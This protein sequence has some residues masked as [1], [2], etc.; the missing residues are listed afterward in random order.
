M[1][2]NNFQ[3][4]KKIKIGYILSYNDPKYIRTIT[5]LQALAKS[6]KNKIYT[7]INSNRSVLRYIETLFRLVE[8]RLKYNP[9]M[10]ILGFRGYEIYWPV[11]LLTLGKPL[12]FDD[13]V[14]PYH[15]IVFEHKIFSQKSIFAKM[16]YYSEKFILASS[17]HIIT[18]TNLLKDFLCNTFQIRPNKISSIFVS[19][20]ESTFN[21]KVKTKEPVKKENFEVFFYGTFLPLHGMEY[22]L[23]AA[24][25]LK[26]LPI[27]FTI[28]GGKGKILKKFLSLKSEL[29]LDNVSHKKWVDYKMLPEYIS[30]SDLCIG[31][32][33]GN[34]PQA[35]LVIT[36]K[37]FQFLSMGKPTIIGS[38]N[39]DIGFKDKYNCILVRQADTESITEAI[40]WCW[41]NKNKLQTIGKNGKEL[42]D[43]KFSITQISKELNKI[44]ELIKNNNEK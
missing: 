20:D 18:D 1:Q 24:E 32:P 14:S 31:G 27:H 37:T 36:G 9:N 16:I 30:S 8:M 41:S 42:Y 4:P 6:D 17:Q 35:N 44:I 25:K 34:T 5:L 40:K 33:L 43:S 7:A 12:I 21:A 19:T 38:I 29:Q 13:F 26:N 23:Y 11:R 2:G 3:E 15:Y 22:I 39:L 10:Y 28:I